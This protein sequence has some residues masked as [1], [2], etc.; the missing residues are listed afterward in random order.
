MWLDLVSFSLNANRLWNHRPGNISLL[1]NRG[2]TSSGSL[3][4]ILCCS[5][6]KYGV[7]AQSRVV[8]VVGDYVLSD[9]DMG[10]RVLSRIVGCIFH[11]SIILRMVSY[12]VL[13]VLL[14]HHCRF[15]PRNVDRCSC[16]FQGRY[17][18]IAYILVSGNPLSVLWLARLSSLGVALL[19]IWGWLMRI[20]S[21]SRS[22]QI[23]V[24]VFF[25]LVVRLRRWLSF[26][27]SLVIIPVRH[28]ICS[29]CECG[30]TLPAHLVVW[31]RYGA[32]LSKLLGSDLSK[33][34]SLLPYRAFR[35]VHKFLYRFSA[36]L[37]YTMFVWEVQV[38]DV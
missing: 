31:L 2:S 24:M 33:I 22:Q 16:L 36:Y 4:E 37:Y 35:I 20:L 32:S 3:S 34:E 12:D 30:R 10:S 11:S 29:L 26:A 14:L 27:L 19:V 8:L 18:R 6:H 38:L 7:L 13:V 21:P 23:P 28:S 17:G 25:Q 15:L 9:N 1:C 5:E